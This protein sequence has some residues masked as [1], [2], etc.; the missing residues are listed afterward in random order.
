MVGGSLVVAVMLALGFTIPQVFLVLAI[1]SG[2][3]ALH[4][5]RLLPRDLAKTVVAALFRWLYRVEVQGLDKL[6]GETGP[7]VIVANHVSWLDGALMACFIPGDTA[8]AIN[9]HIF[10]TWWAGLSRHFATMIPVDPANPLSTKTMIRAVEAGK[11]LII[12]PEGRLTVTGALMKVYDG[13]A[14]IADKAKAKLV[15]VKIEGV[16]FSTFTR[17]KGKMPLRWFPKVTITVQDPVGLDLPATLKG[18]ARRH[19]AGQRLY[20]VL[21]KMMFQ[22]RRTDVAL[23]TA[24]LDARRLHGGDQPVVEDIDNYMRPL[25]YDRL[26]FASLMLGRKLAGLSQPGERVGLLLPNSV[27]AVVT[28]LA[29][30][31]QG[32]VPAMLNFSTGTEAMLSACKAAEIRTILTSRRFIDKARLGEAAGRLDLAAKLVYLEDI[33]AQ[34]GPAAK[35]VLSLMGLPPLRRAFTRLALLLR[36]PPKTLADDPAVVLFTSGSE[37][38]PKGVV[39]S[40]RNLLANIAQLGARI[41]FSPADRVF[42]ALPIFHSFGLTGGFLLPILSGIKTFMYPSPLHYKIVPE[43]IYDT[44]A[45]VMFGTNTFLTGYARHAN[46]YDFYSVRY[47]F[48]GAEKVEAETRRTYADK[49]GLRILEGYGATE[50]APALA[51][52]TPMYFKAGTVGRLLPGIEA[53]LETVPGVAE[54]RQLWVKGPNVMLGYLKEDRPGVLIAPADGWYD[55]GDIVALDADGFLSIVGRAKR[56]VKVAGEMVSLGAVE[57]AAASLWPGRA[58]AAVGV[59]D[60]RKGEQI[61]LVTDQPGA[62]RADLLTQ[63]KARGT[64]ELLVPR[65]VIVVDQLPLLGSGKIDYPAVAGLV[66]AAEETLPPT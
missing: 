57:A 4:I 49:F 51:I 11:R 36:R 43:L 42:N 20:D 13:P 56:F 55:T 66:A 8:F 25:N 9:T 7:L 40:H 6:R 21:S 5:A 15:P 63:A 65:R 37:G 35:M 64:A 47:I 2:G 33:R 46:A 1:A 62:S 53:R 18:R 3:V 60:A 26:V 39:L 24:L 27:G 29:L 50:T 17:L 30:Q 22:T 28:F 52:N 23:F 41:D 19:A 45:T 59:N 12:F 14:V 34:T 61:V 38:L 48:A 16:Q 32:R 44:N 31:S 54:G 10:S 58:H